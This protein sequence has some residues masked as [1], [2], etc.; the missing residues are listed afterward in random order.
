ML[1]VR[2]GG[3]VVRLLDWD[4]YGDLG[5]LGGNGLPI[6]WLLQLRAYLMHGYEPEPLLLSMLSEAACEADSKTMTL[7][8]AMS[9]FVAHVAPVDAFGSR[10]TVERWMSLHTGLVAVPL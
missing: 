7:L 5:S 6:A 1:A 8:G 9:G 3:K 10:R 4:P 2:V